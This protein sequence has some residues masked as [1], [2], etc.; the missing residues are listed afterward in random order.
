MITSKP[1]APIFKQLNSLLLVD[2]EDLEP[3]AMTRI[4]VE[5]LLAHDYWYDGSDDPS[6]YQHGKAE[7]SILAETA[8]RHLE[9]K[10]MFIEY[11]KQ[12]DSK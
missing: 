8:S 9:L 10:E 6:V 5:A 4:F 7:A 2:P 12:K 3:E 11:C 1:L